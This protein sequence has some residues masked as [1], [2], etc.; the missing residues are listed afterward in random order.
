MNSHPAVFESAAFGVESHLSE[1][2]V[3]ICVQLNQG[4]TAAAP[5]LSDFCAARLASFMVPRYLE[6]VASFPR[7]IS[8]KID[9]AP[10]RA[11]GA[12]PTD[13]DRESAAG[14]GAG[15]GAATVRPTA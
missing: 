11:A 6:I 4:A 13:W 12:K 9:K 3:K 1:E 15:A 10:L 2:D 8:D 14:A 7:T 5:E